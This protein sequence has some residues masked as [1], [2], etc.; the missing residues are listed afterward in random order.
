M[1][2]L[3]GVAIDMIERIA[4]RLNHPESHAA[5]ASEPEYSVSD[6]VT[7][8][9]DHGLY[10]YHIDDDQLGKGSSFGNAHA[11]AE[12]KGNGD[13]LNFFSID[14]GKRV[15]GGLSI[16]YL[17][18]FTD[19]SAYEQA[20]DGRR[21]IRRHRLVRAM[22]AATGRM[23]LHPAFQ[24]R[25]FVIGDG[26]HVMETFFLPRQDMD[27]PAAACE[28]ITL[29]NRTPHP[30]EIVVNASLD[31]RGES[32]RDM[33]AAYDPSNGAIVAWNKSHR[34]WIRVFGGATAPDSFWVTTY[35]DEAYSPGTELPNRVQGS[36][37]ILGVLQ[38]N[39]TILP[40]GSRDLRLVAA[41]SPR[42]RKRAIATFRAM[43]HQKHALKNTITHHAETLQTAVLEMPDTMLNQGVQWAKACLIR[44]LARYPIG[45]A[46]TNDPGN[47]NNIVGRDT[48]W[49]VHGSD[50]VVPKAAC[51]MLRIF[52]DHQRRDGLIAEYVDGVE[53][54]TEFHGFNINDNTPLFVMAVA[55]HLEATGHSECLKK[56][57][58]PARKACEL[59]LRQRDKHGLVRCTNQGI[60]IEAIC[61]WR[62]VLR[63]E[64]I[65]GVVTEINSE[66]YAALRS[67][68]R[69]AVMAGKEQDA[70][71][72]EDAAADLRARINKHLINHANGLYIRNI[73]LAGQRFTEATV[74]LVFPLICGVA[75]EASRQAITLRLQ[76]PDFMTDAGIRVLPEE[77]PRWDP[78]S[79]S[80]CLGGVWPG[81][82]WWYAMGCVQANPEIVAE[83]LRRSY[84]HYVS[85]PK[86]FN[87][88]PG[89]FSEWSDGHTLVNRGMR[90]SPWEAPRFLWAAIEGLAGIRIDGEQLGVDPHIPAD[91]KWLRLRD[92][93]CRGRLL[94][95]FLTRREDGFHLHTCDEFEGDHRIE[96][97]EE[98]LRHGVETVFTGLVAAVFRRADEVTICLGNS[99][100]QMALSPFQAHH[101]LDTGHRY[102]VGHLGS[103]DTGW[104]DLGTI[105]GSD[106][107]LINVNIEPR[108][109]ALYRFT[110]E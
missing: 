72:Y 100:N 18:P 85:D 50:F 43:H 33:S 101:V 5:G 52:A 103:L 108:G 96:L 36:G 10:V 91:W 56:L 35:R 74:D 14:V 41:F 73:D 6:F 17:I 94:S 59:I 110:P 20:S 25:E 71:R 90:L 47:S 70:R 67:M 8:S 37:D 79:N 44:P 93:P 57:Y 58:G 29:H 28:I 46:A 49:Y 53:D 65:T 80:G 82:T 32:A 106:L 105:D 99:R 89:Q 55:H 9:R 13:M 4:N 81:A 88:V 66:C 98:E 51:S 30:V 38:F 2:N 24:Q 104:R 34:N 23:H 3:K 97:Y 45:D 109:Y 16:A 48:A 78:S 92:L 95:F 63:N 107:Q 40:G 54:M 11:W 7:V 60:G 39:L 31:L 42:G 84:Q 64:Q 75:D 22:P 1:N 27:D 86:T 26:L 102:R 12:T 15:M 76:A 19:L 69:I 62:N 83:S 68:S 21:D 77:N 87:T 61:G